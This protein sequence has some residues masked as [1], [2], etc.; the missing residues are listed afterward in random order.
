MKPLLRLPS[1]GAGILVC[2]LLALSL[3][4]PGSIWVGTL[5]RKD[6]VVAL[7]AVSAG[8]Y[9]RA[10]AIVVANPP[11]RW[12]LLTIFVIAIALRAALLA[13]P[14]FMS[15]DIY[16]YVWD[17]RVQNA[18][19]NPYRYI[20]ADPALAFLRDGWIYPR[21]NR[22][23]YAHTIYP[24][25]AQL[26]YRAAAAI[27]PTVS[28]MKAAM[29]AIEAAGIAAMLWLLCRAALP[30]TRIAIYVWNPLAVWA[31]AGEG[32]I[33]AAAIGLVT[34]ALAGCVLR[35]RVATGVLLGAAIL[36]KFLPIA[37]APALWRRGDWRMPLAAALT[38][39]ALY[40]LYLSAGRQVLG[41]LPNYTHEENLAH[42]S[43]FWLL[44]LLAQ[45]APLPSWAGPLYVA[46]T[47]ALLAA[48]ALFIIFRQHP[49]ADPAQECI[50]TGRNMALLAAG[51]TA[52]MSPHYP[53]YYVWLAM[54]S[55]LAPIPS[56]IFLSA[57]PLLLYSDPWHDEILIPTAVFVP[58][59]LL[60][61]RDLR[62]RRH[63]PSLVP[64]LARSP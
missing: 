59:A 52:A 4:V 29:L 32:H 8:L 42:G 48:L 9:F 11:G 20:P 38:I 30:L 54:P 36:T 56:V 22:A 35:R 6:L 62:R 60:A 64:S 40:T 26:L 25:T 43:G 21:I 3:H 31:V 41:F 37:V 18:G 34:L 39:A 28:A 53:W 7:I 2:T 27:S 13:S 44:G 14:P 24:P 23:D 16:R 5:W 33:D 12:S 46:V 19:I 50:R 51:T 10:C 57:A 45:V 15:S 58:A 61:A 63:P 1:C 47:A 49:A 17:G 55:C